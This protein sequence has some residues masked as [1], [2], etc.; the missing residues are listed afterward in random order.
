MVTLDSETGEISCFTGEAFTLPYY[1]YT[2]SD[3]T[4]AKDMTGS[5]VRFTVKKTRDTDPLDS[6]AVIKIDEVTTTP[7]P[8][9]LV[10]IGFESTGAND[11]TNIVP[12]QYYYD[13]KVNPADD[14]NYFVSSGLFTVTQSVG[15]R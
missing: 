14:A 13:V 7:S 6:K 2:D 4:I 10:V 1:F 9:N 3:R 15:N 11:G 5:T 12:G 8:T